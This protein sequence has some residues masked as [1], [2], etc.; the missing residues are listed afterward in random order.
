MICQ[1]CGCNIAPHFKAHNQKYCRSCAKFVQK[2]K[3]HAW[4]IQHHDDRKIYN[5]QWYLQH[6][7]Q[8]NAV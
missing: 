8:R 7:E 2:E 5:H 4:H 1:K 6:K 3:I